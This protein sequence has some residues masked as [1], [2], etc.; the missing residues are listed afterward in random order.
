[1]HP[2]ARKG[3]ITEDLATETVVYDPESHRVHC[4]NQTVSFVWSRCDGRT[5]EE[6]IAQRLSGHVGLP[7][8]PDIVRFALR[9]LTK[10]GLLA[11]E[12]VS[13][14][15]L[16][17]PS[18]RELAR[19]LALLGGTAAALMP[20]VSS[21]L[22]PTPSMAKSGPEGY[23]SGGGGGKGNQNGQGNQNDQG[24]RGGKGGGNQQ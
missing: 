13:R 11:N 8:D 15:A 9:Q 23:G 18:R 2:L 19:R 7:P 16:T 24:G 1:M 5:T 20:A 12:S 21:I 14:S 22:A 3:L 6:E 4:L 17:H 10:A